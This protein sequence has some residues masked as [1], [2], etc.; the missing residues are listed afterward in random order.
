MV[1]FETWPPVR[2]SQK[3][4]EGAGQIDECVTHQEEHTETILIM[5]FRNV[6]KINIVLI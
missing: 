1:V 5:I 6:V 2:C 4:L 3:S